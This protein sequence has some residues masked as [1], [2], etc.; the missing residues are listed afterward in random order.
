M[1]GRASAWFAS[2]LRGAVAAPNLFA[3][4]RSLK[5]QRRGATR[6]AVE[7]MSVGAV[8][9][10]GPFRL[11][12]PDFPD[13]LVWRSTAACRGPGSE[14]FFP[15]GHTGPAVEAIEAAKIVCGACPVTAEC[16]GYAFA[17]N[18]PAGIWGGRTEEE[19][20]DLR[21]AWLARR[22]AM[23]G[24][25]SVWTRV[26][27]PTG[28]IPDAVVRAGCRV[29]GRCS[30]VPTTDRGSAQTATVRLSAPL[31]GPAAS[32]PAPGRDLHA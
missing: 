5:S 30:P 32:T 4:H 15:T 21:P 11:V 12:D 6:R 9:R 17:T 8:S 1:R 16:L 31:D 22:R 19:R 2:M 3:A 26:S 29:G 7:A 28:P 23:L 13:D 27:P 10:G 24:H 18:Q 25:P 20:R 14:L